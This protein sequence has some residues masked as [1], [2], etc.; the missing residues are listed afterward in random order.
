MSA[1]PREYDPVDISSLAFWSTT[2]EEREKAF[3]ELRSE[4]PVSWHRPAEGGLTPSIEGGGFWAAVTHE[5]VT[6]VSRRSDDFSSANGVMLEDIPKE[7]IDASSSF[8]AMDAP[9]QPRLRRLVSAAF[10]PKQVARIDD[11]I[12]KHAKTIV[13]ELIETGDCDFVEHVSRRLPSWT[14]SEMMGVEAADRAEFTAMAND[15]VG[16]NDPVVQNGRDPGTMLMETLF[17]LHGLANQ[18]ATARREKPRDDLMSALVSAEIEGERLTD[19]EIAAFFVLLAVAGNDTTRNTI[20]WGMHALTHHPDQRA[21]LAADYENHAVTLVDEL[22]RFASPVMTFR[23]TALRDTE[24]GGQPIAKGD[25]VV[26]FYSSANRDAAVFDEPNRFD[27]TRS[28]NPH[29]GFGGGGPHFC[30]G[31]SLA[32]SQLRSM[33]RELQ[34]VPHLEVGEPDLLVANFIR[35]VS[36]L[37]CSVGAT[38]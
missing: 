26:M 23:R 6:A 24:L 1:S 38:A 12:A 11:Q 5:D 13:D 17:S 35:G 31:A 33:F 21:L 19:A 7:I 4:R 14:I 8:L 34:R 28:P 36:T 30:M 3:A 27:I 32:K 37:P 10:T 15:M 22:V 29:V 9:E 25:W 2:A 20:S 18:M 16:W